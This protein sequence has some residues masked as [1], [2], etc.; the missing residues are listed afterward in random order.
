[1][2]IYFLKR[3]SKALRASSGL[4]ADVSRSIV[5]RGAKNEQSFLASFFG[6]RI[7][8]GRVHSKRLAVSK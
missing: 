3:L 2:V 1:V 4:D 6:I 8:M 7:G 5:S